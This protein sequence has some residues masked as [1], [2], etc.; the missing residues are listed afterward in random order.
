MAEFNRACLCLRPVGVQHDVIRG[1]APMGASSWVKFR[2]ESA[3]A[4]YKQNTAAVASSEG[5]L[6]GNSMAG[7]EWSERCKHCLPQRFPWRAAR[8]TYFES[9]TR[10]CNP[11]LEVLLTGRSVAASGGV[12]PEEIALGGSRPTIPVPLARIQL[13]KRYSSLDLQPNCISEALGRCL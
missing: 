6:I 13:E 10:C 7:P 8:S 1:L 11:G 5:D 3:H 12:C 4:R 9:A 2:T